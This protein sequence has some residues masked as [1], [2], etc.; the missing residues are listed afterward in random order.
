M[1]QALLKALRTMFVWGMVAAG[2]GLSVN[3]VHPFRIN[4]VGSP[5]P[6]AVT[7]PDV[8][9]PESIPVEKAF[10]LYEGQDVLFVDGRRARRFV[11]GHVPGALLLPWMEFDQFYHQNIMELVNRPILVVYDDGSG[12]TKARELGRKLIEDGFP[13]VFHLEGGLKA[14]IDRGYPQERSP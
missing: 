10:S 12:D 7:D 11:R 5:P 8:P 3:L 1:K 13:G 6:P 14:W 2:I 9:F 4:Y